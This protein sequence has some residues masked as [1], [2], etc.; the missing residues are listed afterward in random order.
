MWSFCG[1]LLAAEYG[2]RMY[3]Q[4]VRGIARKRGSPVD[5]VHA[6]V[7]TDFERMIAWRRELEADPTRWKEFFTASRE[8][9]G[10]ER[11]SAQGCTGHALGVG[12]LMLPPGLERRIVTLQRRQV[13]S[14]NNREIRGV[15]RLRAAMPASTA[16]FLLLAPSMSNISSRCTIGHLHAWATEPLGG[17]AMATRI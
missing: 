4:G 16:C 7:T 10:H 15:L 9:N 3:D 5:Q 11:L 2:R 8:Q 12:A 17:D 13:C 14:R 1:R 6:E